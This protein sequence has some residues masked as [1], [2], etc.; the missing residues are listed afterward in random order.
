MAAVR[1]AGVLRG[2][3]FKILRVERTDDGI[4]R[5]GHGPEHFDAGRVEHHDGPGAHAARDDDIDRFA[6][7]GGNGI[8]GSVLM[9]AVGVIN[10]F[11]GLR[12][13]IIDRKIGR[14]AEM[15][16]HKSGFSFAGFRWN[17]N[18]HFSL[19]FHAVLLEDQFRS[20][21]PKLQ[22]MAYAINYK[23]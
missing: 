2:Q 21:S 8:A 3:L 20:E 7:Q 22:F 14:T 17:A 6:L 15:A 13:G 9:V 4:Y 18:L 23:A 12:V 10:D 5:A 11:D 1:C 16:I 19:S